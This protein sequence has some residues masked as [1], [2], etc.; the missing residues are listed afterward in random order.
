M[1]LGQPWI[2]KIQKVSL[3]VGP[4]PVP[5][6]TVEND[7]TCFLNKNGCLGTVL[8]LIARK[9]LLREGI[10]LRLGRAGGLA[11]G[12]AGGGARRRG[13]AARHSRARVRR[14]FTTER[15]SPPTGVVLQL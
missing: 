8:V 7:L 14:T 3:D 4:P 1:I 5:R 6:T 12:C 9:A 10:V 11:A 13:R 2:P 15:H